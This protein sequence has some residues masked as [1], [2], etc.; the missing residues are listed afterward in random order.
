M[1]NIVFKIYINF[2]DLIFKFCFDIYLNT[3]SKVW[4]SLKTILNINLD[5]GFINIDNISANVRHSFE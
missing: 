4:S 1:L 2:A 5:I 3:I